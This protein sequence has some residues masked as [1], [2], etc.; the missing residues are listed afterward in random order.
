MT[1]LELALQLVVI[2]VIRAPFAVQVVLFWVV[3]RYSAHVG[4][5]RLLTEILRPNFMV[6]EHST[7][8]IEDERE[9]KKKSLRGRVQELVQRG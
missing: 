7:M 5:R 6:N 3:R 1:Y 9:R 2:E 8:R 4:E